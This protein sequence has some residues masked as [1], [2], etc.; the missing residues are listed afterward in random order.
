ML[1]NIPTTEI[2][3]QGDAM[4]DAVSSCVHC[5]FCLPACPTYQ[6][7]GEEMDSPRGRIFLMKDALEGNLPLDDV[8][9]YI[10]KCLGCLA[11][12]TACPSGVPYRNL[13]TPFRAH[14]E[15]LRSRTLFDRLLRQV[16]LQTLPYP[17]RFRLSAKFGKVGA[18]F[19]GLMPGRLRTML[20]L[21][22]P[23]IP[24]A[25]PLPE[26]TP[27]VGKR[28]ARVALLAGCAQQ[29]L[30]PEINHAAIRVLSQSG[31]EVVVPKKQTCCGA[32]SAHT[33]AGAQAKKFAK[34]N[35][36]A[37]PKD[38]DCLVTTA[39]G[40]GSGIHE[41][42]LWLKG[43]SEEDAAAE[44]GHLAKD[45]CVFLDQLGSLNFAPLKEPLKVVYHDAC[46]L[47]HGQ[48]VTSE[49][50]KL[51]Q[52]IDNLELLNVPGADLCCGSAGTYNLEQ[53]QTAHELGQQK[54]QAIL[55]TGAQAI[56]TGNIGCLVQVQ[57][58]LAELSRPLPVR[59]TIEWLA[60]SIEPALNV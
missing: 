7:L 29:V 56:A 8:L 30:A 34:K 5:G 37:F 19:S 50:R 52:Q 33:G 22:P 23:N 25:K 47:S 31:V 46:H 58:H 35:I 20:S 49:P 36:A 4:A 41:Y 9:P 55:S 45:I 43:E 11:C 14:S 16:V 53:P 1:H 57:N 32:L 6:V 27:A 21:L 3:P 2:G 18:M 60:D 10:D 44:L 17:G 48:G 15:K 26:R 51:L 40:C 59:H 39:A 38:V 13:I 24:P 12:E 42:S 28:R 54:A